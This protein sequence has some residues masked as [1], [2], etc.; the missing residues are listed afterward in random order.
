MLSIEYFWDL[1]LTWTSSDHLPI[2][3]YL[4]EGLSGTKTT[5]EFQEEE[6]VVGVVHSIQW[7]K[8]SKTILKSLSG[9]D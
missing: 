2:T 9:P 5:Q 8:L 4:L 3:L 6:E 1:T 7:V